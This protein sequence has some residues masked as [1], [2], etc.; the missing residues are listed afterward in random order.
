MSLIFLVLAVFL[1]GFGL[2]GGYLVSRKRWNTLY[3]IVALIVVGVGLAFRPVCVPIA[4]PVAAKFNPPIE[5]RDEANFYGLRYFRQIDGDWHH[6]KTWLARF[7][8]F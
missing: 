5:Q 4:A 3:A 7:F 2:L 6:C 8:F 1:A